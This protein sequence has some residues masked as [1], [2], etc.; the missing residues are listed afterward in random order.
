MRQAVN[1]DHAAGSGHGQEAQSGHVR[2]LRAEKTPL[3]VQTVAAHASGVDWK[4]AHLCAA[5]RRL[6]GPGRTPLEL[7]DEALVQGQTQGQN[8]LGGGPAERGARLRL[9]STFV[10]GH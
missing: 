8:R 9:T 5:A 10:L 3:S 7:P 2:G 1:F 4:A 6:P